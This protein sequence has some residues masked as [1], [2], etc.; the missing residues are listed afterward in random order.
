MHL[1]VGLG[2]PGEKYRNTRHNIGFMALDRISDKAGGASWKDKFQAKIGEV[3]LSGEKIFMLKPQ[4]YMNLSGQSV[5]E[6]MRF[7]N[8]SPAEVTVFHD[9]LDL[10]PGKCRA[11]KGGGHAGHNGLRSLNQHIGAEYNRIRLGIGH[12]GDKKLVSYYVLHDFAKTDQDWLN[13]LLDKVADAASLL[14]K[15]DRL[16]FMNK[17]S[18]TVCLEKKTHATQAKKEPTKSPPPK[19]SDIRKLDERNSIQKLTDKFK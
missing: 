5:G 17:V 15:G 2:N 10:P 9:E 19:T 18:L 1:F 16:G 11:K 14:A 12:P 7:Y 8:L 4:T 13:P 6:A 3:R